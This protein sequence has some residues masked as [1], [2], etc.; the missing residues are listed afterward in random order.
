[1]ATFKKFEEIEAWQK[2]RLFAQEIFEITRSEKFARDFKLID[3]I[4][5]SSGSTMDN[6]AEGFGRGGK[7]E[8]IQF[9]G[10]ARG[11]AKKRKHRC[12]VLKNEIKLVPKSLKSFMRRQ[13]KL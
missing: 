13:M 3:Q 2:A 1:M 10:I 6:I 8:F 7:L 4:N 11:S 12:S 5:G 9:L